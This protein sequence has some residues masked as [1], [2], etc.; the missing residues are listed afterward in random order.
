M[1]S[2]TNREV[3]YN[4]HDVQVGDKV[5]LGSGGRT[6]YA[7]EVDARTTDGEIVWVQGPACGRRLFHILDGYD[8]HLAAP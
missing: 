3:P 5:Q 6:E 4:W 8:L 2:K 7:G 1:T